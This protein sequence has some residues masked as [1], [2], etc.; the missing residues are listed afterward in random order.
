MDVRLSKAGEIRF[1]H[2][3]ERE[4]RISDPEHPDVYQTIIFAGEEMRAYGVEDD[5]EDELVI[6]APFTLSY[7]GFKAE[8]ATMQEAKD[9]APE[10]AREVLRRMLAMI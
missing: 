8:F 10:F 6:R 9:A 4:W 7:F 5:E 2:P 3:S 1:E